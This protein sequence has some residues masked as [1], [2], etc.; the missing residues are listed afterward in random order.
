MRRQIHFLDAA[1]IRPWPLPI[2]AYPYLEAWR[3]ERKFFRQSSLRGALR[4]LLARIPQLKHSCHRCPRTNLPSRNAIPTPNDVPGKHFCES[5]ILKHSAASLLGEVYPYHLQF[6]LQNWYA[7]LP[8]QAAP[9]PQ[10]SQSMSLLLQY[11]SQGVL[12]R[13][14]KLLVRTWLKAPQPFGS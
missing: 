5:K 7:F 2:E 10:G 3:R 13:S 12:L 1:T 9:V 6:T 4:L 11:V 8:P 14:R